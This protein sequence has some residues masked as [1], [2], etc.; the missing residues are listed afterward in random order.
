V[1]Q[2]ILYAKGL[3]LARDM[4]PGHGNTAKQAALPAKV[5]AGLRRSLNWLGQMS[6]KRLETRHV[7]SEGKLLPK[8]SHTEGSD[9]VH[10][11][12]LVI[13]GVVENE[14]GIPHIRETS[15]VYMTTP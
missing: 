7:F 6:N 9:F 14:L 11:A 15:T 2:L 13:R 5:G 4:L 10:D 3:D 8:L 1:S 12:N